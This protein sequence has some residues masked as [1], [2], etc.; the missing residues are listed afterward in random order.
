MASA[1]GSLCLQSLWSRL[2]GM[3]TIVFFQAVDIATHIQKR[4]W[5]VAFSHKDTKSLKNCNCILI[6]L[7]EIS[8]K[9]SNQAE[10]TSNIVFNLICQNL[11]RVGQSKPCL[12]V[13]V[14]NWKW[15]GVQGHAV[16]ILPL[17]SQTGLLLPEIPGL[18][19]G[20][21]GLR[22]TQRKQHLEFP[23]G[24][25]GCMKLRHPQYKTAGW[26]NIHFV[27]LEGR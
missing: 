3:R 14:L 13:Y 12:W 7:K 1:A 20:L 4:A 17:L 24:R 2:I 26:K 27:Q 10:T 18:L 11:Y 22:V 6:S 25:A 19:S 23:R 21:S 9:E 15:Q 5:K 8:D 16:D